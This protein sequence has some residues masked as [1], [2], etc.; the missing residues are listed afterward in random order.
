MFPFQALSTP[1]NFLN[2]CY[3]ESITHAHKQSHYY[4]SMILLLAWTNSFLA[5]LSNCALCCYCFV[6]LCI[7]LLLFC[8]TVHCVVIVLSYCAL[9]CYC[10]VFLVK[11]CPE[12]KPLNTSTHA[13]Y[14][15]SITAVIPFQHC[16]S[17]PLISILHNIVL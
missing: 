17:S 2:Y 15:H 4:T 7:V 8:L 1:I 10:F 16:V 12:V 11:S 13:S 5:L 14:P 3:V 9:C 6:L